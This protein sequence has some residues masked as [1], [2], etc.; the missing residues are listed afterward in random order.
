MKR[1]NSSN[2]PDHR[3]EWHVWVVE[4][5]AEVAAKCQSWQ[6]AKAKDMVWI[7]Y[8]CGHGEDKVGEELIRWF[9]NKDI[10]ELLRHVGTEA[11]I[12][13]AISAAKARGSGRYGTSR[14]QMKGLL[15]QHGYVW[16]TAKERRNPTF[17]L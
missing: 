1:V 6:E 3:G 9:L 14:P 8:W 2:Q 17:K 10:Q 12:R 11:Q 4:S 15:K 5:M 16:V 13:A 7:M